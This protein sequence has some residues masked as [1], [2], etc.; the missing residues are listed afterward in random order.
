MPL[1]LQAKMLR[2]LACGESQRGGDNETAG[3]GVR[4]MAATHQ[5]LEQRGEE[6]AFRLDLYP[7]LAVFPVEV[8][9]LRQRMEDMGDLAEHFL[10]QMGQRMPRKRLSE[11]AVA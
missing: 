10:T 3:V 4:V 2:S 6:S 8:P 11:A 9:A 7:R 1:A 5:P